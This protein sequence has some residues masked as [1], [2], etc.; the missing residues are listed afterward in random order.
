MII[1]SHIFVRNN[2]G[3]YS[4]SITKFTSTVTSYK[5]VVQYYKQNMDIETIYQYYSDL[6]SI[7]LIT[8]MKKTWSSGGL[9]SL[10]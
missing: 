6:I 7:L 5:T 3:W 4:V 9:S 10:T 8:L 2:T 1:N